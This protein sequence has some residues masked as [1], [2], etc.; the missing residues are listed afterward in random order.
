MPE[1]P[2]THVTVFDPEDEYS[3]EPD[4]EPVPPG[5]MDGSLHIGIHTSIAGIT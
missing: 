2:L 4:P 1:E 5:W 3:P